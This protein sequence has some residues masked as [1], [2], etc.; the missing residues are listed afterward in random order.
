MTAI[1][2][3]PLFEMRSFHE[4]HDIGFVRDSWVRSGA[5][6]MR[7]MLRKGLFERETY[8]S[9]QRAL[10]TS[11]IGR[12]RVIIAC[13]PKY[14]EQIFGWICVGEGS[15]RPLLHYI[16]IK[17]PYRRSF[18][19][20]AELLNAAGCGRDSAVWC[21]S[22][23]SWVK[24]EQAAREAANAKPMEFNFWKLCES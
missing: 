21:T 22:W 24:K 2:A 8:L 12:S 9:H 11:L 23:C 7:Q 19:I 14:P 10:V 3:E 16:Y 1:E 13:N 20:S 5:K 15:V 17:E 6:V 4:R 18:G